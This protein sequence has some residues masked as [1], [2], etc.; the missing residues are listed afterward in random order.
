MPSGCGI[1]YCDQTLMQEGTIPIRESSAGSEG[2]A[3]DD[4]IIIDYL[5]HT[6]F[7]PLAFR[8]ASI[9]CNLD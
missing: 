6:I 2:T 1:K 4:V 7:L 8:I 9:R 3:S 5:D